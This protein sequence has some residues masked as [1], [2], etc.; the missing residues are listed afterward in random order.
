MSEDDIIDMFL[1]KY[2]DYKHDAD[3]EYQFRA[4]VQLLH[5][6]YIYSLCADE[7]LM[8]ITTDKEKMIINYNQT[9]KAREVIRA[10]GWKKYLK[11]IE[12]DKK[13]KR[14]LDS[15]SINNYFLQWG[16]TI[17]T[18]IVI[19]INCV[20]D[21]QNLQINI[22]QQSTTNEAQ[23]LRKE[24]QIKDQKIEQLQAFCKQYQNQLNSLRAH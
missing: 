20:I 16:F 5:S 17:L 10:G 12:D 2:Y 1:D 14:K 18:L 11:D 24:M 8:Q 3:S 23:K 19:A 7:G 9:Y 22:K 21:F 15:I 13:R 6:D 4:H